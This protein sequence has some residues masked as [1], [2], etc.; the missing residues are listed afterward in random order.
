MGNLLQYTDKSKTI[1][2]KLQTMLAEV[3]Y[4]YRNGNIRTETEYYYRIRNLLKDFY[5]TLTSPT[6]KY[7][8]AVSTPIS[9]EYNSMITESVNDMT[10]IVRDCETLLNLVTQSFDDAEISRSMLRNT[11][12]AISKKI[13]TIGNSVSNNHAQGTVVFTEQFTDN[14][15]FGNNTD[16]IACKVDTNNGILTL[17]SA[18]R[19]PVQ[20]TKISID[21][22]Y[23]NGI[24][25]NSHCADSANSNIHYAGQEG[26]HNDLRNIIASSKDQWFEYEI[27]NISDQV[28]SDCNSLGFDYEE[29]VSWITDE[30]YLR[31]KLI[32]DVKTNSTCSFVSID[33]YLSD[34]KGVGPCIVEKC[35]VVTTNNNIYTVANNISLDTT[36]VFPFPPYAVKQIIFTLLQKAKYQT[37]VGHYYYTFSKTSN[38]SSFQQYDDTD[39]LARV[40]GWKPSISLLGP[41]YDPKTKW[42]D[43]QTSKTILPDETYAKSNLFVLPSSTIEK[44]ASEELID[45]YRYMIGIRNISISSQTFA[46]H[47]EYVSNAYQ[48]SEPITS[49]SLESKEYIPGNDPDIV[50]YYI[51]LNGGNTWHAIYPSHRAYKG[52]YK[53]F[54]NNNII[55]NQISSNP[56]NK[57]SKNLTLLDNPDSIQLKIEMD[58][59]K[60]S[61]GEDMPYATPIVYEYKLK[62][63]IGGDTIEY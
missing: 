52:I 60:T 4:D 43:Y 18:N 63:T 29:G 39:F 38:I 51:S 27:F 53:Y 37:K 16:T 50:K 22:D 62:L 34:I 40:D 23:S 26:L 15:N 33:P 20:I 45:A 54:I 19:S 28:R 35:E 44:K 36:Q 55:E 14:T 59:P 42:L 6:F 13:S 1:D 57:R 3:E 8:P 30:E 58:R 11:L 46:T 2:L 61:T 17:A 24:P 31:L 10:Y 21:K 49:V 48:T 9:S 56:E 25:G 32:C 7:R 12:N 47:S 5:K 41:K